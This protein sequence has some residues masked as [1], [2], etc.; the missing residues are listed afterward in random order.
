MRELTKKEVFQTKVAE[1]E[2]NTMQVQ[3]KLI[4]EE[5]SLKKKKLNNQIEDM[6]ET[7]QSLH[8]SVLYLVVKLLIC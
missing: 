4:I 1:Y 5:L 8:K 7:H 2:K 6:K 3:I